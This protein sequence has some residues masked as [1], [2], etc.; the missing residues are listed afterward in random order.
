[1]YVDQGMTA[2]RI[3]EKYGVSAATVAQRVMKLGISKR[4]WN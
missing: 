3:A 4:K 1:M 2:K